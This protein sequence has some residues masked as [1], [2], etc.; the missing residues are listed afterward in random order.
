MD[1]PLEVC[2]VCVAVRTCGNVAKVTQVTC[3]HTYS[4]CCFAIVVWFWKSICTKAGMSHLALAAKTTTVEARCYR[5][6]GSACCCCCCWPEHGQCL[7]LLVPMSCQC[8]CCCWWCCCTCSML[9]MFVCCCCCWLHK[10]AQHVL[11]AC[12]S[13]CC[14]WQAK[15]Q[16]GVPK[17]VATAATQYG[18]NKA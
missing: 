1:L 4:N 10:H 2:A 7:Q 18:V 8:C 5:Y 6:C 14:W 16:P 15:L 11:L 12:C 9:R 17:T 3:V 13:W